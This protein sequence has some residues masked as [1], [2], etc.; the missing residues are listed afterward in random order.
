MRP[1]LALAA[2]A[3]FGVVVA[4]R[5][6]GDGGQPQFASAPEPVVRRGLSGL[7]HTTVVVDP[8]GGHTVIPLTPCAD[9][10]RTE[11]LTNPIQRPRDDCLQ[12]HP[13]RWDLP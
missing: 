12:S 10:I 2:T 11:W 13:I 7:T 6:D 3:A 4:A 9:D 5:C 1:K 8:V